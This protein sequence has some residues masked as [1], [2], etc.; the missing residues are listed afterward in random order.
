MSYDVIVLEP[1]LVTGK[2]IDGYVEEL[3][4]RTAL[5]EAARSLASAA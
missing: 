2:R 1:F 5:L 4:Q 3:A